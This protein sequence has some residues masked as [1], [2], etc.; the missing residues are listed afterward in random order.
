M[1]SLNNQL[2]TLQGALRRQ[3]EEKREKF[4]DDPTEE[5]LN[6]LQA[7]ETLMERQLLE[8]K[9][10]A[11]VELSAFRQE[12]VDQFREQAKPVLRE[13]A[14]AR[15]LSIVVPKNDGLLLSI[16]PACEITDEVAA[17]M[18]PAT[19]AGAG[20]TGG[21]EAPASGCRDVGTVA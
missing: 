14:A 16:D 19:N 3:Y 2:T 10:K 15:G 13:V 18:T 7:S 6:E 9:R 17:R 12:L 8:R 11:E 5:Q 4:G 1:D 20:R 21:S